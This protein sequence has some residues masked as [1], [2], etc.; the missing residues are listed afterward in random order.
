VALLFSLLPVVALAGQSAFV[1]WEAA[2][3]DFA[4]WQRSGVAL[5]VDGALV[6]HA[7]T[8]QLG[9]DPYAPGGYNGGNFYNGGS[10]LV[11][12]ALSPAL[13]NAFGFWEAIP[14]WEAET[15]AGTW[16]ET[17]VRV[18]VSGVWTKWYNLGVW[19][20]DGTT[21]RRHSAGSQADTQGQV[22]ID[23]LRITAKRAATA[24]QLKVR[25]FSADGVAVPRVRGSAIT[26]STLAERSPAIYPGN[27]AY[28][29]QVLAVPSCSQMVY[30]DGGE[31]WCS[32][33][34]VSMVLKYWAGDTS[35]CEPRVRATVSGVYDWT[36]RGHGNWPFNT[37]HAATQGLQAHVTRF[38]R[39][40]QLEPWIAA[41]VP[42]VISVAWDKGQLTGAPIS[43]TAGHLMLLVGFDASGNPVVND[44]AASSDAS[45]RRTY[46]RSELE[47]LWLSSSAGTAY[48]IY[49]AGWPVPAL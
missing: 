32:P 16:V 3:G 29:G 12:E 2:Q 33:T 38:T 41:G 30:P 9:T 18:Q 19:A 17:Q 24:F 21:V 37:A 27:P 28:W 13:S 34:S 7:P 42:V 25:L 45:V 11:G 39:L 14:S 47:P 4:S 1:R 36:Y 46:F 22:M 20:Q 10:F 5:D 15:P 6:L 8:A 40:S 26:V 44:P 48:L 35:A 43:S 31:V 23:T 49:P